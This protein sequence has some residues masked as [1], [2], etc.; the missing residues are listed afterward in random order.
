MSSLAPLHLLFSLFLFGLFTTKAM[1]TNIDFDAHHLSKDE[2]VWS[3]QSDDP[4]PLLYL[5]GVKVGSSTPKNCDDAKNIY[6]VRDILSVEEGSWNPKGV[7]K[8]S[9]IFCAYNIHGFLETK[10]VVKFK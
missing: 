9:L 8:F 10:L 1:A 5:V 7:E 2:V 3:F 6:S 4:R